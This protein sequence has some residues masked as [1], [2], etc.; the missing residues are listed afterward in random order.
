MNNKYPIGTKIKYKGCHYQDVNKRGTIVGY[1]GGSVWIVVP[2]SH[3][4]SEVYQNS[5]HKWSTDI[6]SLEILLV[7]NQQLVFDFMHEK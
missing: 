6:G 7:P 3:L 5:E 2:G 1:I 4:A